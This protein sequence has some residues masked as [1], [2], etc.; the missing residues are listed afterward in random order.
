MS[1]L[2][3]YNFPAFQLLAKHLRAKGHGVLDPSEN[4]SE[5]PREVLLAIDVQL[6]AKCDAVVV[7]PGWWASE[8]ACLEVSIARA[9]KKP[10]LNPDLTECQDKELELAGYVKVLVQQ[11]LQPDGLYKPVIPF[12]MEKLLRFLPELTQ[13]T[14]STNP[15]EGD[16]LSDEESH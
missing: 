11:E 4:G 5:L 7:M 3:D 12:S 16:C 9:L 10:I 15:G 14:V 13:S 8:G 2:P 1:N 6:V